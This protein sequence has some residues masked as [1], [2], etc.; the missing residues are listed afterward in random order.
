[1][2][3]AP[4][5]MEREPCPGG[6]PRPHRR[7]HAK[8]TSFRRYW[9]ATRRWRARVT[10]IARTL[11]AV[12]PA[13]RIAAVAAIA[14]IVVTTINLIYHVLRKPTEMF[15]FVSGHFSKSPAETW[16]DYGS[17]LREYSTA[18]IS[19]ELLAA[20]AQVEGAGNPV[21]RTYWRWQLSWNRLALYQ[22]A[23]SGVGMFQM[24]DAAFEEARRFCIRDH[25]VEEADC[26]FNW[27]YTRVVPSHAIELAA[28]YLNRNIESIL[29]GYP[30][31]APR[32]E[33]K[34]ELA[35]IIHLCGAGSAKAFAQRGFHL[36][37]G[38]RCGEHDVATY[39]AR[40]N[41]MEREFR[42]LA[43]NP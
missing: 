7:D 37:A 17:L 39:L 22:P 13:F 21:A 3:C 9:R 43:A 25:N 30:N 2:R 4:R 15:A 35:S 38:E 26:R 36:R 6:D 41:A 27:L 12:Q 16:R 40:V 28:V 24:T 5:A 29:A 14:L 42:R 34:R 31:T 23:S 10:W 8:M 32:A 33:H 19:P 11:Y 20:L 1:M 18:A